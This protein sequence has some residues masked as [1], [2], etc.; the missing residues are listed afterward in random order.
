MTHH[1]F[2][3]ILVGM[4]PVVE[5]VTRL[6]K[7]AFLSAMNIKKLKKIDFYY[8]WKT[9]WYG[10]YSA[11]LAMDLKKSIEDGC[12]EK[13]PMVNNYGIN[14]DRF[15]LSEL[16]LD[17]FN[18]FKDTHSSE[19]KKIFKI[20]SVY[21]KKTLSDLLYEVYYKFPFFE[22]NVEIK[23]EMGTK[24]YESESYLNG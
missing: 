9:S 3:S 22:M 7:Y 8:D 14:V 1:I 23:D 20:I 18:E 12:V 17:I 5:G 6:Q 13:T 15:K 16:G 24:I 2:P 11:Q 4:G 21:Q 19:Y 10:P